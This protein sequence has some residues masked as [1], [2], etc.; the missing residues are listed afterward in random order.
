MIMS[1][2]VVMKWMFTD[3]WPYPCWKPQDRDLK[4]QSDISSRFRNEDPVLVWFFGRGCHCRHHF[5]KF[6]TCTCIQSRNSASDRPVTHGAEY[7]AGVRIISNILSK[8]VSMGARWKNASIFGT[9]PRSLAGST[10]TCDAVIGRV[11]SSG[12]SCARISF[13]TLRSRSIAK[14]IHYGAMLATSRLDHIFWNRYDPTSVVQSNIFYSQ[15]DNTT[16]CDWNR[17]G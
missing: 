13:I 11:W 4:E 15:S 9:Q 3:L 2:V 16:C 10:G 7:S 14:S 8:F 1:F 17:L 5:R 6:E 12:W